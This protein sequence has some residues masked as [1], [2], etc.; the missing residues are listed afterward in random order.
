MKKLPKPKK[1]KKKITKRRKRRRMRKT[2]LIK[3]L[4]NMDKLDE[5]E[6]QSLRWSDRLMVEVIKEVENMSDVSP[7][8]FLKLI[9]I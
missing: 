8:S 2:K 6:V 5:N 3:I 1:E 4:E 7:F 9:K